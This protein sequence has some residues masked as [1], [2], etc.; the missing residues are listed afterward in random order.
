[1]NYPFNSPERSCDGKNKKLA[2]KAICTCDNDKNAV[3]TATAS[4]LAARAAA[5]AA[6][7]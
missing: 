1:V 7:A 6:R 4:D 5:A 3:S 2:V